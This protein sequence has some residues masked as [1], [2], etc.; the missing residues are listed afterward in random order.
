MQNIK[1]NKIIFVIIGL[2][3]AL[4][5]AIVFIE[6]GFRIYPKVYSLFIQSQDIKIYVIGESTANGF[7]YHPKIS[8]SKIINLNFDA[9]INEQKIRLVDI[10]MIGSSLP[11]QYNELLKTFVKN[12]PG[13]NDMLLIYAGTNETNCASYNGVLTQ[14]LLINRLYDILQKNRLI[15]NFNYNFESIIN[16]A[17]IFGI[18][19]E[20]IYI[21]T[22]VHTQS[23][24]FSKIAIVKR[25]MAKQNLI[26][27]KLALKNKLNLISFYDDYVSKKLSSNYDESDIFTDETHI[28]LQ[29][30]I[31]LSNMFSEQI[32]KN[33][34]VLHFKKLNEE[35]VLT[36]VKFNYFDW[37]N[38]YLNS[39]AKSI[40]SWHGNIYL[41]KILEILKQDAK[42]LKIEEE[43]K[44]GTIIL[45]VKK[46]IKNDMKT[47]EV[48]NLVDTIITAFHILD[49]N[50]L[51]K[52][53]YGCQSI[54]ERQFVQDIYTEIAK[55]HNIKL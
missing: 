27:K 19:S 52:I 10:S 29:T 37:I 46:I 15:T 18:K 5:G 11:F 40:D 8:Y 22:I 3:I 51:D 12:P 9:Q 7:P 35:E 28:N 16:L 31:A 47:S 44:I 32:A 53:L 41:N 26:I 2:F 50:Y 20:N 17:K 55:R 39:Y 21:S 24:D 43:D 38:V 45:I 42:N 6:I 36:A 34:S 13:K 48:L 14:F 33:N 4:I 23:I 54:Q 30:T 1:L 49:K 25:R